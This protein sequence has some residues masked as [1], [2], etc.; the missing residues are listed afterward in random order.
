MLT[1]LRELIDNQD[2]AAL[3]AF[4]AEHQELNYASISPNGASA[5]WWALMPPKGKSV[6]YEVIKCLLDYIKGD[7]TPLINPTQPLAGLTPRQYI[8]AHNQENALDDV[9]RIV[10]ADEN[11]YQLLTRPQAQAGLAALADDAQNVH[12]AR[13]SQLARKN[14]IQLYEH[15]IEGKGFALD[16]EVC[17][18]TFKEITS[19]IENHPSLRADKARQMKEGLSYC[20]N[21]PGQFS[22]RNGQHDTKD[23]F[24]LT[25][26]QLTSLV[27]LA[28]NEKEERL[29]PEDSNDKDGVLRL[30]ARKVALLNTLYDN[31]TA[32]GQGRH[33]CAGGACHRLGSS[34][35]SLHRLV[36][37]FPADVKLTGDAANI[38][39]IRVLGE[40]LGELLQE[41][42][43]H[44]LALV[45]FF[46]F[47]DYGQE[48]KDKETYHAFIEARAETLERTLDGENIAEEQIAATIEAI[49]GDYPSYPLSCHKISHQLSALMMAYEKEELD[50]KIFFE[51]KPAQEI[52]NQGIQC[53]AEYLK[54]NEAFSKLLD[55]HG[56]S[57]SSDEKVAF[58]K[59]FIT[60]WFQQK[61][62]EGAAIDISNFLKNNLQEEQLAFPAQCFYLAYFKSQQAIMAE[63]NPHQALWLS[64]LT[65]QQIIALMGGVA[66]NKEGQIGQ[67]DLALLPL[68]VEEALLQGVT[69]NLNLQG[70]SFQHMDLRGHDFF[71]VNLDNARFI[72]CLLPINANP[73]SC[74]AIHLEDCHLPLI[75]SDA[76]AIA[77]AKLFECRPRSK[78]TLALYLKKVNSADD[79]KAWDKD[80]NTALMLAAGFGHTEAVNAILASQHCNSEVLKAQ[81]ENGDTALILAAKYGH[82]EAVNAILTS[83]H[84]NSVILKAQNNSGDTALISAARRGHTEA[85]NAILASQHCNSEVLK[86]QDKNNFTALIWATFSG[87]TEAVKAI[88]ASPHCNSEALKAQDKCGTTALMLACESHT[89]AMSAILASPHCNSEVLKAQNRFGNTALIL[90]A[91]NGRT[92]VVKAILES[93]HCNSE[94]LKAQANYGDTALILAAG[95]GQ[96]EAVNAILTSKHCNSEVLKAP[97]NY[98]YTVLILAAGAGQT[99]AVNAILTS[100]HCNSEVLKAQNNSGDTALIL[101]AGAGQ[102]EAVNAILTSKH[103]NSEVLKAQ[104]NYG[105]T[106]LILAARRGHTEAV[107]AVL[108]SKHCNSEVLKAQNNSGDTALI[109]AAR[110]ERTEAVKAILASPHCDNDALKAQNNSDDTALIWAAREGRTEA[111]KAI[112]ASPHCDN[113]AL[114]AQNNSDDTAL[115]L[116]AQRRDTEAVKAI[117]ASPHCDSEVLNA[118]NKNRDTALILAARRGDT[119]AVKAI[120]GSP[121]CNSEVLKAQD[122]GGYT[123]L[124]Q[125][126]QRRD[127]EAVNA[128]LASPHCNSKVLKAQ[129]QYGITALM[130]VIC[131]RQTEALRAIR[132]SLLASPH[133][134]SEVLNVRSKCGET[135]LQLAQRNNHH[136]IAQEIAKHYPPLLSNIS[137]MIL[138][139]FIAAVG[140]SAIAIAF[141]VLN[142]A[143][144]GA[145]GIALATMGVAATLTGVGL[146]AAGAHKQKASQ[147]SRLSPPEAGSDETPAAV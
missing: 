39:T 51:E 123:A 111:V 138:G 63:N 65:N 142:V 122:K 90:A 107:N 28:A 78:L 66:Q 62:S 10:T 103:C 75:A 76:P 130:H 23:E 8:V 83:P 21:T 79:L 105:D 35:A 128:I 48:E 47:E 1:Q 61:T 124:I 84:C 11:Q 119:E 98:G 5:L 30:E 27:W 49:R 104:N 93:Q 91:L 135:A 17:Q 22:F 68:L 118:Q 2:V 54:E 38:V 52:M 26:A 147:S 34:L 70:I 36:D 58:A 87:H 133:C 132:A 80:G 29:L 45:R 139:G 102:T 60:Q 108:T 96:T 125:A 55:A 110:L 41:E 44:H 4:I 31:A 33:S 9:L 134:N 19:F 82:T 109:L 106:A 18:K 95:K 67:Q 141:T 126:A 46:S 129:D 69:A 74:E 145:A 81:N 59:E 56:Y 72:D 144:F 115:I 20:F 7:G 12:D 86:A 37:A 89:E 127:T 101:A 64:Q 42:P 15:Y 112:L 92:E 113:D 114:K 13:I 57:P 25:L 14:T 73:A 143:T 97:N 136:E 6:S 71:G 53:L 137:M 43:E 140:I 99:E 121:H 131:E 85:V 3:T 24:S 16:E 117:L 50:K 94:V 120:L 88:L 40:A 116:A 100:K 146:F 77:I 32:Y